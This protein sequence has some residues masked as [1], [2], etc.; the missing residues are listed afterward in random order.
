MTNNNTFSISIGAVIMNGVKKE[1][2]RR[3]LVRINSGNRETC[4]GIQK[5]AEYVS[6]VFNRFASTEY[7]YFY[8][9]L[10]EDCCWVE[11]N[12]DTSGLTFI[13]SKKENKSNVDT[14]DFTDMLF[15]DVSQIVFNWLTDN[16]TKIKLKEPTPKEIL[17]EYMHS[18]YSAIVQ[19]KVMA[20]LPLLDNGYDIFQVMKFAKNDPDADTIEEAFHY[21]THL[22]QNE[23]K[24]K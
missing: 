14:L 15:G 18:R 8:S 6:A 13:V 9:E 16:E 17:A 5:I 19:K 24:I 11:I 20:L 2:S 7:K 4:E 10:D 3:A 21:Y 22:K 1:F 12:G 23:N